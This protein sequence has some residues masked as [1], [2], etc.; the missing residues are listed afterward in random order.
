MSVRKNKK[1]DSGDGDDGSP[2]GGLE[3]G[4]GRGITP[5]R[6][7]PIRPASDALVKADEPPHQTNDGPE[8]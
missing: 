7:K 3:P 6:S 2:Q 1:N 4:G 8:F 5:N